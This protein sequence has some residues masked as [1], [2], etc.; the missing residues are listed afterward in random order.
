[1]KT[2]TLNTESFEFEFNNN[3]FREI[4]FYELSI[5][6]WIIYQDGKPRYYLNLENQ[7]SSFSTQVSKFLEKGLDL[8]TAINKIGIFLGLDW[9]TKHNIQGTE[10][11]NSFKSEI[12]ILNQIDEFSEIA[13]DLV[14]IATDVI[15]KE[16]LLNEDALFESKFKNGRL[17][18][19]SCV[20]DIED[21]V[22]NLL[23]FIFPNTKEAL[24][25]YS[26]QQTQILNLNPKRN[27]LIT[28]EELKEQ[29]KMWLSKS[30]RRNT[31]DEYGMK[32]IYY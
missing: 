12:V 8:E 19:E 4:P 2:I 22:S 1:M 23:S 31:M 30:E 16:T 9:T 18:L 13:H 3:V 26:D 32:N 14:F 24:E 11:T 27:F 21:N 5:Q 10:K 20:M 7:N 28:E 15:D 17:N 6:E 25:I 29:Y